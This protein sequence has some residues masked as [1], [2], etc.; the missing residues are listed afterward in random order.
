MSNKKKVIPANSERL[1]QYVPHKYQKK[2]T[3]F[4][5]ANKEA[6]LFLD[7]GL[8]KTAITLSAIA[9]LKNK[10]V[11]GR[12]LIVAPLLVCYNVWPEEIKKWEQF[13]HLS[14]SIC[15]G[16]HKNEAIKSNS[17]IMLINYEGLV[18]LTSLAGG[19]FNTAAKLRNAGFNVIVF[20]ELSKMKN[21]QS[22]RFKKLKPLLEAFTFRWGLTGS[23]A[24]NGLMDLFGECFVLDLGKA[25]GRYITHFRLNYFITIDPKGVIWKPLSNSAERIFD[26]IKHLA[27]RMKAEDYLDMP[28]ITYNTIYVDMDAA[29]RKQYDTLEREF[30]ASIND[31]IITASNAAVASGKLRQVCSGAIYLQDALGVTTG[32][33]DI[34]HTAKIDALRNL[35][36]ELQGQQLL[37][38]YEFTHEKDRLMQAL[39]QY[40]AAF[41]VSNAHS[42]DIVTRW[43]AGTLQILCGHPQ[44]MGHGLNLQGSGCAH[45]CWFT[46][47][48]NFELFDQFNRRVY[49]QGTTAQHII[50]HTIVIR[51]TIDEVVQKSL[52]SKDKQQND[53]FKALVEYMRNKAL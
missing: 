47:T 27:L 2:A 20:D 29:A 24:A 10:R 5:C 34:I 44:S 12:V 7:P 40:N 48:W 50:V 8:G 6:A 32:E 42:D 13:S 45:V 46:P 53:L 35:L 51:D 18:W 36:D 17:D 9:N 30:I 33:W 43:N 11:V 28:E 4:L 23:P 41:M 22:Q 37:V 52:R 16:R 49:R 3:D 38:G 21:P 19:G 39:K 25:L 1:T 15:H 14:V 26:K 31:N